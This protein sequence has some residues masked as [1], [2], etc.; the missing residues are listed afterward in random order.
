MRRFEA[1]LSAARGKSRDHYDRRDPERGPRPRY[2][3][4]SR[5]GRLFDRLAALDYEYLLSLDFAASTDMLR[6]LLPQSVL[7]RAQ[8]GHGF[9][10]DEDGTPL[11]FRDATFDRVLSALQNVDPGLTARQVRG[12]RNHRLQ[13]LEAHLV[14]NLDQ[15]ELLLEVDG[16]P[17]LG[18]EFLRGRVVETRGF[19][20]GLLLAGWMDDLQRRRACMALHRR[21]FAGD[22]LE[23]AGGQTY[24]V[25]PDLLEAVGIVDPGQGEFSPEDIARLVELGVIVTADRLY[26]RPEH[27]QAYFRLRA[28]EGVCDDLALIWVGAVFGEDAFIGAFLM[29]AV[30]TYDKFLWEFRPGG[31]DGRLATLLQALWQQRHG[32]PLVRDEEILGVI[33][34][35]AKANH[36]ACLLSS[37][38]RRFIQTEEGSRVPTLWNHWRFV[39]GDPV[40]EIEL[41]YSRFPSAKFYDIAHKRLEMLQIDVPEADFVVKPER[42]R[43]R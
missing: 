5:Q 28:G 31:V 26:T 40:F 25:R 18:V 42:R 33:R 1:V 3:E 7:G 2:L 9:W 36:P 41:G 34:F 11:V 24:V 27:E 35:A 37:S 8:N 29:D 20:R 16:E 13:R 30:D 43:R 15:P 6:L 23:I 39:S 19:L 10:R 4:L 22:P 14:A 21:T 38:H 12:E 32:E 17:L